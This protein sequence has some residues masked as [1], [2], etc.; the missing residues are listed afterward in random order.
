MTNA[1][2]IA[3]LSYMILYAFL[4]LSLVFIC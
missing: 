4:S 2:K 3:L 1:L